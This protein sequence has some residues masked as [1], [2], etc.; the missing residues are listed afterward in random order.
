M[1]HVIVELDGRD[2]VLAL[3]VS[4]LIDLIMPS[5]AKPSQ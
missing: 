1:A 4:D 2:I 5:Q 3:E